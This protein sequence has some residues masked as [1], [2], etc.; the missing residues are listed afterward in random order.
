MWITNGVVGGQTGDVFLVYAKTG[1]KDISFFIVEK[2]LHEL[3]LFFI[4]SIS[5]LLLLFEYIV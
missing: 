1:P 5:H 4:F 3:L 2:V